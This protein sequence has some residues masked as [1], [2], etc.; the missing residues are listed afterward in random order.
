MKLTEII[1]K[2]ESYAP[3]EL[4]LEF[5]NSGLNVGD[6]NVEIK[7]IILTVDVTLDCVKK[8]IES[9]ANLII[10]HHPLLFNP[11]KNI[12][13]GDMIS[14][15]LFLAIKNE[16]NLYSCHTN[17]DNA[18]K[19]INYQLAKLLGGNGVKTLCNDG[20]GVVTNIKPIQF[21]KLC[22]NVASLIDE[23]ARFYGK[24]KIIKNI[25]IISG[26]GGRDADLPKICKCLNVDTY[27]SAEFKHNL[28]NEFDYNGINVIECSHYHSEKIFID[29]MKNVL[30]DI[31]SIKLTEYYSD[32]FNNQM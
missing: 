3:S 8:A 2:I 13:L 9:G 16:I 15:I 12:V 14:D 27:I 21:S 26:N 19:G 10:S 28:I 6:I 20:S 31:K 23:N 32:L 17:M 7:G 11:V 25:A 24:D 30:K 29:I 18:P 22:A 1:N 5:D 4:A